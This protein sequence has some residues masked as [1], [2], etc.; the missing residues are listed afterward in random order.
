MSGAIHGW[1]CNTKTYPTYCP[2]CNR[3][4]FY[5]S[6]NCGCSV[7]FNK[8]GKP[9]PIHR[10]HSSPSDGYVQKV[11]PRAFDLGET[12]QKTGAHT[13]SEHDQ[14]KTV[15]YTGR[16]YDLPK[17]HVEE[18][19]W[20]RIA[21]AY[22]NGTS[23]KGCV[24]KQVKGG[25]QVLIQPELLSGFLPASQVELRFAQNL[26]QYV[27][28]VFEMKIINVDRS[29]NDI[30]LSRRAWLEAKLEKKKSDLLRTLEVGQPVM[31]VVKKITDFGAFINLD[32]VDG[33]LHKTNM[34]RKHIRHPS[35]VI[36]VG[37]KIEVRVIDIDK[38]NE[39][40]SLGLKQTTLDPW[41]NAEEKYPVGSTV[42][43]TVINIVDYGAFVQ[44]EEGVEGLIHI[45]QLANRRI[46]MP[47]EIVTTGEALEVKVISINPGVRR[48]GLSLKALITE[49]HHN[50]VARE[51]R[52]IS[53]KLEQRKWESEKTAIGL[54]LQKAG[55]KSSSDDFE[56]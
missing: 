3:R 37:D 29:R 53:P 51:K 44:L 54:A 18:S 47:T 6:C 22:Q 27:G 8:L 32:G 49:Q 46:E 21:K 19:H 50:S 55:A 2:S 26:E 23:V 48:I 38:E 20:F 45:S 12:S 41:K 34:A 28:Q 14:P 10:C 11:P 5:F 4:V 56:K 25:L 16:G 30:V 33:L 15:V 17:H 31:G 13:T 40:I 36:S 24:N 35:E 52:R 9:W 1:W 7:F 42:Q 43:G 39:K